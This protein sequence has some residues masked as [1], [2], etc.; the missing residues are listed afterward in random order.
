MKYPQW[1]LLL[2]NR[3]SEYNTN[4]LQLAS[5]KF[6]FIRSYLTLNFFFFFLFYLR[7]HKNRMLDKDRTSIPPSWWYRWWYPWWYP[8][9]D[10][11]RTRAK[12]F[13]DKSPRKSLRTV[14]TGRKFRRKLW[15]NS[16]NSAED[17][18]EIDKS[19]TKDQWKYRGLS[20]IF[21]YRY[22]EQT[23]IL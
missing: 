12:D 16:V 3:N 20:W 7:F 5:I 6:S 22:R 18:R 4:D 17:D 21:K 9:G 10:F 13:K 23:R 2:S 1:K 19:K 14:V 11:S 15:P 8:Y